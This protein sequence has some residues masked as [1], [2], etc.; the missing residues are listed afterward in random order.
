[1]NPQRIAIKLFTTP[2]PTTAVDLEPF[3]PLFH[4]FIQKASVPGLLVDVADYAHVP[5]GP[6]IILIGHDVDYGLDSV[7]GHAGLLVVRKRYGVAGLA[8]ILRDTLAKGFACAKAIEDDGRTG[9]RFSPTTIELQ[10]LDRLA[11][12]NDAETYETLRAEVEPVFAQ[13][14]GNCSIER[15]SGDDPRKPASLVARAAENVD[16]AGLLAKFGA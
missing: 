4:E 15:S 7:G 8:D 13:L 11:A 6:G 14:Y 5:N 2:D 3:T 16:Y 9:V 1:V 10:I 12:P